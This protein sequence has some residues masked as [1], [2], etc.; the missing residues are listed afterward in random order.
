[1]L[2]RRRP[3]TAGP[4]DEVRR[5][6]PRDVRHRIAHRRT[7]VHVTMQ[8]HAEERGIAALRARLVADPCVQMLLD[9]AGPHD[10]AVLISARDMDD[11]NAITA[12]LFESEPAVRRYE[13]SFVKRV[14]KQSATVV[15]G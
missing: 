4:H 7:L 1:M 15:L 9:L 5:V 14:H 13:T 8:E 3:H 6:Q 2:N 12:L 10:L 11:Y